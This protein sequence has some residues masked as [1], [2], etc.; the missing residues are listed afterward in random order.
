MSNPQSPKNDKKKSTFFQNFLLREPL[1]RF[2]EL[3]PRQNSVMVPNKKL[4]EKRFQSQKNNELTSEPNTFDDIVNSGLSNTLIMNSVDLDAHEEEK[5]AEAFTKMIEM[6]QWEIKRKNPLEF[7]FDDMD[8]T[9]FEEFFKG[10]HENMNVRSFSLSKIEDNLR[11]GGIERGN[12]EQ[13]AQN[14]NIKDFEFIKIISKGAFGKVYLV[15]RKA[16]EDV[17]AMKMVNF[18]E[19]V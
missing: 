3:S 8:M 19:K 1:V 11:K 14:V 16:T 5:K 15:K 18:A 6:D 12:N 17:Y 2:C 4:V 10:K 9:Y 13:N 7:Y